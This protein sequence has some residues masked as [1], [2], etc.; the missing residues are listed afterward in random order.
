MDRLGVAPLGGEPRG[1]LEGEL[2]PGP[3][4]A[5]SSRAAAGAAAA[6]APRRQGIAWRIQNATRAITTTSRMKKTSFEIVA[7]APRTGRETETGAEAGA[8]LPAGSPSS[9]ASGFWCGNA[10]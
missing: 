4:V 7:P 6:C 8:I 1:V 5:P 2:R 10:R 9:S 3:P